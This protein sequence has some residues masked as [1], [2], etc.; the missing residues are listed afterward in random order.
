MGCGISGLTA[1]ILRTWVPIT[2]HSTSARTE[3][4]SISL[5]RHT[6]KHR[7]ILRTKGQWTAGPKVA[8]QLLT[9]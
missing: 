9:T 4:R 6:L 1:G 2:G 8:R 3:S 5:P 7:Q